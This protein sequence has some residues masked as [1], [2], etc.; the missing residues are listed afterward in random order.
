LPLGEARDVV[1]R[2]GA[3]I[4]VGVDEPCVVRNGSVRISV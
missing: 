2:L 3:S 4:S 1:D